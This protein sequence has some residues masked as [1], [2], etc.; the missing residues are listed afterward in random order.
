M[1]ISFAYLA[2]LALLRLL[3][4]GRRSEFAKDIELLVLH[5]QL[6]VRGLQER[7]PR[8]RP[9]DRALL[10]ALTRLLPQPRRGGLIVTPQTL[11]RWHRE[12]VRR[13][14]TQ[15][16]RAVGRRSTA[17]CEISCCASRARTRIR[18][19]RGSPA[20]CAS[21]ACASH[22]ARSGGSCLPTVLGPRPGAPGRAGASSSA[23]R[24]PP[25]SRV[26]SSP[27]RRSRCAA[28]T[29][30][31]SSNS[32]ADAPTWQAARPTRPS[33]RAPRN[34]DLGQ[35]REPPACWCLQSPRRHQPRSPA[36]SGRAEAR[37]HR[38]L[39]R[40]PRPVDRLRRPPARHQRNH[41]RARRGEPNQGRCD[42]RARS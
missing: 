24:L 6:S 20:S 4:R 9:A 10:A 41:L 2:F 18:G 13:K 35:A 16:Q 32:R 27:S 26:I 3:V 5:H 37:T 28:S 15:P 25:S 11:L 30:S 14:W 42:P 21:L 33:D 1:F 38:G 40:Q 12:L 17:R 39:N 7:R 29:C 23:G 34:R 22:P 8:F 19:T 36:H 31:S